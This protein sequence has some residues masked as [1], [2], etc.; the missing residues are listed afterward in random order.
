M[1]DPCSC[2]GLIGDP[3]CG[4]KPVPLIGPRAAEESVRVSHD[5]VS[6]VDRSQCDLG[7]GQRAEEVGGVARALG[8]PASRT[9]AQSLDPA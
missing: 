3:P 4:R 2:G 6:V 1:G 5:V 7:A 9:A 8:P